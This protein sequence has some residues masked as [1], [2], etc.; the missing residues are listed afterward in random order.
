MF[1]NRAH[2]PFMSTRIGFLELSSGVRSRLRLP[3]DEPKYQMS[4]IISD[5]P[6]TSKNRSMQRKIQ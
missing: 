1:V 2:R 6:P 4:E 3:S 5:F